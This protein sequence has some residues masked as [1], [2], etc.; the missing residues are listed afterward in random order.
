LLLL[1]LNLG[2]TALFGLQ[3]VVAAVAEEGKH[4]VKHPKT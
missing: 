3:F 4:D 1:L 2:S